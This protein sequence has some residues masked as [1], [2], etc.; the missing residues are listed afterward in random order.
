MLAVPGVTAMDLTTT[1]AACT[2]SDAV[3]ATPLSVAVMVEEPAATPEARPAGVMVATAAL[4][5]VHVAEVV[6]FAVVLSL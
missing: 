2:V 4:D 1:A 6:T 3:P 5:D